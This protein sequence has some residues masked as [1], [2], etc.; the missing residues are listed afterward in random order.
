ME[1][2]LYIR[3]IWLYVVFFSSCSTSKSIIYNI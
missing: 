1:I 3:N 2:I